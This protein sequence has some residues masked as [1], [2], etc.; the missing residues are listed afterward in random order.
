M[1]KQ[2]KAVI[3]ALFAL[4]L[5]TVT[6]PRVVFSVGLPSDSKAFNSSEFEELL[7][8]VYEEQ[9]FS[10]TKFSSFKLD[11]VLADREYALNTVKKTFKSFISELALKYSLPELT[12]ET[13]SDYNDALLKYRESDLQAAHGRPPY[14]LTALSYFIHL[15]NNSESNR[16]TLEQHLKIY[17]E[18]FGISDTEFIKEYLYESKPTGYRTTDKSFGMVTLVVADMLEYMKTEF[19]LDLLTEGTLSQYKER[20]QDVPEDFAFQKK[21]LDEFIRIYSSSNK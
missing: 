16:E 4:I 3:I 14:K 2:F 10:T 19:E 12:G 13:I 21:V 20:L 18:S 6:V 9:R 8:G 1:K 17:K 5:L 11:T 7:G 15:Y